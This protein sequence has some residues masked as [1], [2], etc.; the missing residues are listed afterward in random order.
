[1]KKPALILNCS[2]GESTVIGQ[3][4]E[5]TAT[6]DILKLQAEAPDIT[7]VYLDNVGEKRITLE[8]HVIPESLTSDLKQLTLGMYEK[9]DSIRLKLDS[10]EVKLNRAEGLNKP[11]SEFKLSN[12]RKLIK[13]KDIEGLLMAMGVTMRE[14]DANLT[15]LAGKG[16]TP[17]Q[18]DWFTTTIES[19]RK[20]NAA[21]NAIIRDRGQLTDANIAQINDY[22]KD[23][24]GIMKVGRLVFKSDPTR[25]KEYSFTVLRKRVNASQLHNGQVSIQ[26]VDDVSGEPLANVDGKLKRKGGTELTKSVKRSEAD[27]MVPFVPVLQGEYDYTLTVDGY[28]EETGQLVVKAGEETKVVV[29]MRM[30]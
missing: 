1:M 8:Q 16:F 4:V 15:A 19:I 11:I 3:F 23:I 18:R 20:D 13:N 21:Q 17:A 27:G 7:L 24:K 10:L 9:V 30:S 28:Q 2:I 25:R 6:T 29:R 26:A 14:V 22:L 12:I 5:E